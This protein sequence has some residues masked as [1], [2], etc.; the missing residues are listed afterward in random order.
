[1]Q[2]ITSN[3]IGVKSLLFVATLLLI[4]LSQ[5]FGVRYF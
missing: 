5:L 2:A 3:D 4:A 1:M